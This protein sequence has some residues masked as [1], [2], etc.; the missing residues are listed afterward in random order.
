MK[1]IVKT[2][3]DRACDLYMVNL[4]FIKIIGPS[5]DLKAIFPKMG[6]YQNA[7]QIN[8]L[9]IETKNNKK[10]IKVPVKPSFTIFTE[11]HICVLWS[12]ADYTAPS[13]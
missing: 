11:N 12:V 2:T 8:E 10:I 7:K 1:L 6:F 9:K 5:S 13:F 4:Y 3:N